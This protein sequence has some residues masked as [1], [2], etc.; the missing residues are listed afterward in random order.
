MRQ[1]PGDT[2]GIILLG[3]FVHN[4]PNNSA[5]AEQYFAGAL[6]QGFWRARPK[7]T[8]GLLFSY[9]TVSGRL[10]KVQARKRSWASRSAT[11]PLGS[12]ATR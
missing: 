9:N 2:D 7:D 12:S 5:Y 1:G 11:A 3:G 4:D 6:D 10:G 8:M